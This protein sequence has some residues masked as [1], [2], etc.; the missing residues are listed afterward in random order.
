MMFVKSDVWY[1]G[2]TFI[3]LSMKILLQTG[4]PKVKLGPWL[5]LVSGNL[6]LT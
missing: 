4:F 1:L 5:V 3:F 6:E 2:W